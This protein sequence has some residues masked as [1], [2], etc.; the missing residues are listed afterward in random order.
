MIVN[1]EDMM[2]GGMAAGNGVAP[3][4]ADS[5]SGFDKGMKATD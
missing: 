2:A 4:P 5:I 1:F 3:A